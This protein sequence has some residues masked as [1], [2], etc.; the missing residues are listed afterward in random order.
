MTSEQ[1][2]F[3]LQGFYELAEPT[4][5]SGYQV[6]LIKKH[7]DMVFLHE[8]TPSYGKDAAPLEAV[9]DAPKPTPSLA[10][11]A[12]QWPAKFEP[13]VAPSLIDKIRK[14]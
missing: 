11:L 3:W 7:L 4:E 2:C 13:Q 12:K 9:H 8:I 6:D 10:D 14:S 1:F 5:L